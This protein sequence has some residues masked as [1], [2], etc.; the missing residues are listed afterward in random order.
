MFSLSEDS[1][2]EFLCVYAKENINIKLFN[3]LLQIKINIT[4][5]FENI[6]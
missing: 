3:T 4:H 5:T 1:Q 2:D 6:L